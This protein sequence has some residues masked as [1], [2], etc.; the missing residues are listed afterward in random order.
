MKRYRILA[1]QDFDTRANILTQPISEHWEDEIKT[2]HQQNKNNVILRLK[3]E[4]GEDQAE[5]K[6]QNFID[7]GPKP[8]SIIAFHNVF[9]A[10]VLKAFVMGNYYPALTGACALGERILNHLILKLRDDFKL[11]PEYKKNRNIRKE[12]SFTAWSL[13]INTLVA[14]DVLLPKA[15]HNFDLLRK[16]R[17]N[18]L[19]F[20]IETEQDTRQLALDAI[21]CLQEIIGEQ[22]SGFGPQPWFITGIPGEIYIKKEWEAKPFIKKMYCLNMPFVGPFHKIETLQRIIDPN[23]ETNDQEITDNEFV[24]IRCE[25]NNK[26]L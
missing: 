9:F 8:F 11:T 19:H 22:F 25:F 23:H 12:K 10:Q 7:L 4:F 13:V 20:N 3:K 16:Y 6:I 5:Q 1:F 21:K 2:Q 17:N 26:T 24:Q 15:A 14:W 18:S